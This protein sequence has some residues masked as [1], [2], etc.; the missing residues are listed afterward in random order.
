MLR[1]VLVRIGWAAPS[2][3]RGGPR[4]SRGT[5]SGTACTEQIFVAGRSLMAPSATEAKKDNAASPASSGP[6]SP[7]AAAALGPFAADCANAALRDEVKKLYAAIFKKVAAKEGEHDEHPAGG[8]ALRSPPVYIIGYRG[9]KGKTGCDGR[10]VLLGSVT[11]Q[12]FST[13]N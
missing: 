11:A 13:A 3:A 7:P 5:L 6:S 4:R 12:I 8:R 2:P 9:T 10:N 1:P